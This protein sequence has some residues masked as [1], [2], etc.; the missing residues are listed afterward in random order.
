MLTRLR[1]ALLGE[2][3][4]AGSNGSG[5][6]RLGAVA[7]SSRGSLIGGCSRVGDAVNS[8]ELGVVGRA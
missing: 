6:L 5:G 2:V 7:G 1:D 3:G 8:R 4:D